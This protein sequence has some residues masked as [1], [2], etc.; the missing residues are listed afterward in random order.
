MRLLAVTV[1]DFLAP[2]QQSLFLLGASGAWPVFI[3]GR[4]WTVLS[5]SWLHGGL[6]HILFNMVA[7][8]CD[9]HRRPHAPDIRRAVVPA[10]TDKLPVCNGSIPPG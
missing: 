9:V 7:D 10:L 2:N 5:A 1:M 8:R 4:W 3:F 6:L